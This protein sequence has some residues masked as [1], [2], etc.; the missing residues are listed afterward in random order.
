MEHVIHS[1]IGRFN[2]HIKRGQLGN[3]LSYCVLRSELRRSEG[4][5]RPVQMEHVIHSR[6]GRFNAHIKRG[7][8]GNSL[9]YCV[10]RSELRRSEGAFGEGY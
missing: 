10:L 5:I 9:S 4:A 2:A 7:Q 8:L 3:S 6:I 1:R